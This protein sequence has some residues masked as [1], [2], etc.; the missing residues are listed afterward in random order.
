MEAQN[1]VVYNHLNS[2]DYTL[3]GVVAANKP[4]PHHVLTIHF[5]SCL[6]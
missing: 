5:D 4:S 2:D 3:Y 1:V 6:Y